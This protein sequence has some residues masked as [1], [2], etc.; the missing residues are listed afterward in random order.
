VIGDKVVFRFE[1]SSRDKSVPRLFVISYR[2][3]G[4]E[5]GEC[6]GIALHS[7]DLWN[8]T[9]FDSIRLDSTRLDSTRLD[10]TRLD[11]TRLDSARCRLV[12]ALVSSIFAQVRRY[13]NEEKNPPDIG[14][15]HLATRMILRISEHDTNA[16]RRNS[17]YWVTS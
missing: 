3:E 5:E 12:I 10:S 16:A 6:R 17:Q 4:G 13:R 15:Q 11:S 14:S 2:K 7:S 8:E 9:R 1:K